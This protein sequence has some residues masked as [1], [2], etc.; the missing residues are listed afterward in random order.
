MYENIMLDNL[1]TEYKGYLIR[2]DFRVGIQIVQALNDEELEDDER[3]EIVYKLLFGNGIPYDSRITLECLFWFLNGGV[4]SDEADAEISKVLGEEQEEEE[5]DDEDSEDDLLIKNLL[6]LQNR[7]K[8][9]KKVSSVK[10]FDYDYDHIRIFSAFR[11]FYNIDLSKESMH[12]FKF[13][14]LLFDLGECSF[15]Q[16]IDYRTADISKMDKERKGYYMEMRNKYK[17]PVKRKEVDIEPLSEIT[18]STGEN[19]SNQ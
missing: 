14:A 1:P 18:N 2:T 16:V 3:G 9:A 11:R 15:T 8:L 6:K 5:L 19:S 7:T 17:I 13:Q 4:L 12:W 10:Q